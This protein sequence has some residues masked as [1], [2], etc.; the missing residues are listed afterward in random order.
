MY[1]DFALSY[2]KID[3]HQHLMLVTRPSAQLAACPHPP[4]SHPIF[5]R[6]HDLPQGL[7][8]PIALK[9]PSEMLFDGQLLTPQAA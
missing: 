9:S 7:G 3:I 2:L 4:P 8:Y 5:L 1:R 6:Y